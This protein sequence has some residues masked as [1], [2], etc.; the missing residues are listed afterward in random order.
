MKLFKLYNCHF[1]NSNNW[2]FQSS[3][4]QQLVRSYNVNLKVIYDL[5]YGCHNWLVEE[6]SGGQHAL[7]L[8]YSKYIKFISS[9]KENKRTS[10]RFLLNIVQ[11]DVRSTTGGNLRKIF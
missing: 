5:P 11:N 10:L 8:I 4:F 9:L 6:L 1:T 3:I 7:V 2:N